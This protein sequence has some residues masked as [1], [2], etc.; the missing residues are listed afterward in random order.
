M[1]VGEALRSAAAE[2]PDD[3]FATYVSG[4]TVTYADQ[5][6]RSAAVAAGLRRSGVAPGDRVL[7]MLDNEPGFLDAW[8]ACALAGMVMVPLNTMLEG[9]I[10]TDLVARVKAGAAIASPRH[11]AVLAAAGAPDLR[12]TTGTSPGGWDPLPIDTGAEDPA[13]TVDADDAMSIIFTSGTTGRSKGVVLSHAHC[14]ARSRSYIDGL[15]I[16]GTDV[17]YTCL[18]LFHN[19]AQM[20]AVLVALLA[21]GSVA[22]SPRFSVSR[23][24]DEIAA[25]G[26]T[27]VTIIGRMANQLLAAGPEQIPAHRLR[28]ACIVPPPHRDFGE[29]FG[30]QVVSQYYGCTEMIPMPPDVGQPD[31]PGSCGRPGAGYECDVVDETG[32][33]LP[34]GRIGE[35]VA[36]PRHPSGMMTGYF[37]MP[38]ETAAA[39][40]GGWFRTGD[41]MRRDDEGFYY[42][43]GRLADFIR[44]RGENVSAA[45]IEAVAE[46]HP[47]VAGA[48][49]VGEPDEWGE[50]RIVLYVEAG[51]G[52]LDAAAVD[53]YCRA[54]LPSFMQPH[55][56]LVVD[57]L[58]RN[59]LG[60]V[61]KH[62]L[63]TVPTG[64][65]P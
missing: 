31:R 7:L 3:L 42:L 26:A 14:V 44:H 45:E 62:R 61:E 57:A 65:D 55:R 49:A 27:R 12:Y 2:R 13:I 20:A 5:L 32:A 48:A 47:Q 40:V 6:R 33:S 60:R 30:V 41:A 10:L 9:R 22:V 59:A 58:P 54:E 38:E 23:F 52:P 28:T 8:F 24:W 36:R 16:D 29:R 17:M 46:E 35:M 4:E 15:Q 21:G 37:A 34:P 51:D 43:V 50:E 19:N 56:V 39:F 64:G 1:T 53:A 11:T 18:P 25:T 63:R